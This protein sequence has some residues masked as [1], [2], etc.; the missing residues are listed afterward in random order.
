MKRFIVYKTINKINGKVYVGK[1][2]TDDPTYFGSGLLLNRA[3]A[4]YGRE[5]FEKITLEVCES[6][7]RMNE[8]ERFWIKKLESQNRERGYNIAP[9]GRGGFSTAMFGGEEGLKRRAVSIKLALGEEGLK[10]RGEKIS[11]GL[12]RRNAL[13]RSDHVKRVNEALTAEQKKEKRRKQDETLGAEGRKKRALKAYHGMS[14]EKKQSRLK[15]IAE[16]R[17]R[18]LILRKLT[19]MVDMTRGLRIPNLDG[20]FREH[21]I[22]EDCL[23]TEEST[24]YTTHNYD[25]GTFRELLKEFPEWVDVPKISS[26][27]FSRT[28]ESPKEALISAMKA[29]IVDKIENSQYKLRDHTVTLNLPGEDSFASITIEAKLVLIPKFGN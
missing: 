17:T 8:Q 20:S 25:M 29:Q 5:N 23:F 14:E 13:E 9:G 10:M 22:L 15:R 1:N 11:Q 7:E 19:K 12:M 28:G 6:E 18:N 27:S 21:E 4:K 16:T 3:I 2:S 24:V 26:D